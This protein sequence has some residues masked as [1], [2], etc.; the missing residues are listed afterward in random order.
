MLAPNR[1]E[2]AMTGPNEKPETEA[3]EDLEVDERQAEEV[4]GGDGT[5]TTPK[6]SGFTI[7]KTTDAAS[8]KLY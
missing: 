4:A 2:A 3:I 8:T 1:K 5:T 6:V 7:V